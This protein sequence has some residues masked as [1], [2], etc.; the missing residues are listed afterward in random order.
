VLKK[1]KKAIRAPWRG[2]IKSPIARG[3]QPAA[4]AAALEE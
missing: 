3:D 1:V 2:S 4:G